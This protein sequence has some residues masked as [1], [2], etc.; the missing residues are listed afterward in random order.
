MKVCKNCQNI[1]ADE[2][3]FCNKC[4]AQVA[5][6][7]LNQPKSVDISIPNP[8]LNA[9]VNDFVMWV[10]N[11]LI[12]QKS[13]QSDDNLI[14]SIISVSVM[15]FMMFIT[16][17]NVIGKKIFYM[18]YK[19]TNIFGGKIKISDLKDAYKAAKQGGLNLFSLSFKLALTVLI[20]L[21]LSALLV[22]V[23]DYIATKNH[24][25]FINAFAN[26]TVLASLFSIIAFLLSIFSYFQFK[27]LVVVVL[28]GLVII[29]ISMAIQEILFTNNFGRKIKVYIA[30]IY[31]FILYLIA[32]G[33]TKAIVLSMKGMMNS[34]F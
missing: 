26:K 24:K 31:T 4:G 20:I 28:L 25:K 29:Q 6:D 27:S 34:F 22:A 23:M 18:G 10:K 14:Y 21:L 16:M 5:E 11:R 19:A 15:I 32:S 1:L 7:N 8:L 2:A 33:I 3:K 17:L 13:T 30:M 9:K 12:N